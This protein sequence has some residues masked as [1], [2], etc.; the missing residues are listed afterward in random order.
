MKY[1]LVLW[2]LFFP[3]L[4]YSQ[5]QGK[6]FVDSLLAELPYAKEDTNKVKLL[7]GLSYGYSNLHPKEGIGYGHRALHLAKHLKWEKGAATSYIDIAVNHAAMSEFDTALGYYSKASKIYNKLNDKNGLAAVDANISLVHLARG[8]YP[9]ALEYAFRALHIHEE[10]GDKHKQ[11][12]NLENIGTIYSRQDNK[13]KTFEYYSKALEIYRQLGN[14]RAM[15]RN[16]GN[17][18]ILADAQG[19]YEKALQNHFESLKINKGLGNKSGIQVNLANIGYVY[20]HMRRYDEAL[21][22]QLMALELSRE[23]ANKNG[24]AIDMGNIGETYYAIAADTLPLRGNFIDKTKNGNLEKA[25]EYLEGAVALCKETGFT[26]PLTEF[27]QYLSD[28]YSLSSNHKKAY[29]YY[30]LYTRLKDS[31]FSIQNQLA[32]AEIETRR[33]IALKEKD[34]ELKEK[35]ISINNL[36][37]E[38]KRNER[39][40]FLISIVL[41]LLVIGIILRWLH[42]YR[43]LHISL[44]KEK[45]D[46]L[47]LIDAQVKRIRAQ[48]DVLKE[49]AHMQAHDVRGPVAS[50]LGLVQLFNFHDYTDP[51]N[52]V[53]IDGIATATQKLDSAVQEVIKRENK[54]R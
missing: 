30:R 29:E 18:G 44:S 39:I 16:L 40:I 22:Y 51:V 13:E 53:V 28:A 43:K 1:F 24:I 19:H 12:I 9:H 37:L 32:I 52:K 33:E 10:T 2:I 6:A 27:S 20:S 23:L 17:M 38:K 5:K 47:L 14:E 46:H 25:I 11:G 42:F 4:I 36:Q 26:G 35:Q 3:H 50:I 45:Q 8:N 48:T 15:A 54:S 31:V 21:R 49:I 41:L 7:G 34:I